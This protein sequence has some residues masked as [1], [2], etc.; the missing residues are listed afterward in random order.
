MRQ[1]A[2]AGVDQY[3]IL[4]LA[5]RQIE[6]YEDPRAVEGRYRSVCI[7]RKGES[8]SLQTPDGGALDVAVDRLLP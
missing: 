6:V 5:D 4:D 1:D 3:V 2:Q 8:V 7:L